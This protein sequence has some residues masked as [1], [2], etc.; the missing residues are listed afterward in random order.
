MA[1]EFYE[2]DPESG[3]LREF[4]EAFGEEARQRY[5]EKIYDLAYE[6]AQVLRYQRG[7]S[8]GGTTPRSG[9]KIYLAETTSDLQPARDRLQRELL[10]QGHSVLPDRPLP[11]NAGQLRTA[12]R[13][14]LE[15]CH[16]AV[17]LV[18]QRYGLVPEDAD[19]SIVALQNQI[20]AEQSAT[21]GLV[22]LI[23]MPKNLQ[24]IDDRQA[25]FVRQV[26]EDPEVHCGAARA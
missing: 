26:I 11:L 9:K 19:R 24:M 3:R 8:Q 15:Q 6:I 22:R 1:F 25:A 12:I 16:L 17:H 21:T 10:E 4:D 7:A 20:A 13:S 23:W 14:Y 5:Y 18:G 2:R